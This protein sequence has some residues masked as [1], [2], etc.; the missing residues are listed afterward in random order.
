M[1]RGN[2]K[3]GK[4]PEAPEDPSPAAGVPEAEPR[5]LREGPLALPLHDGA[6]I[7]PLVGGYGHHAEV[8]Q[9]G[10]RG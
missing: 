8:S 6:D 7:P 2:M 5:L 1:G 10:N 4:R 3:M 9:G